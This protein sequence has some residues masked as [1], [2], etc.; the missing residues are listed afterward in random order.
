MQQYT[1][2]SIL[3]TVSNTKRE[4]LEYI[5]END[6]VTVNRIV[7]VFPIERRMVHRH[8]KSL[9]EG[10]ELIKVGVPPKV[11]YSVKKIKQDRNISYNINSETIKIINNNFTLLEPN[12]IEIEG[13]EGFVVWCT[14]KNRNYDVIEKAN[15]YIKLIKGYDNFKKNG[16]IDATQKIISTFEK[17]D[18]FLDKLYYL[19]P[20]SFPVFGKTKMGQWLFHA[21]QTQN[22]MLMQRVIY[23][24]SKEIKKLTKIKKI[25]S[26]SF[27]PPT[28]PRNLQFMSELKKYLNINL[29]I[30]KIEKIK[31]PILI[32][33]KGLKD[34]A[35]RIKNA[36]ET[37]VI[38][39]E[40]TNYKKMLLIDDFTGSG[41]TLNV[42]AGKIKKQK[43]AESV[44]GI[45]IAGSMNG[46]EVIKEL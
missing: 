18:R 35:D 39:T 33:Q 32:Q 36:E 31:T 4:I 13:F 42:L 29:P 12:G 11:Y 40:N 34:I 44:I 10:G 7:K 2:H 8:L 20:Y 38:E 14:S 17:K 23:V 41:S 30:I 19:Y 25:D 37:M 6:K 26:I 21:K 5:E 3:C 46:F 1:V 27:I 9:L 22:K 16:F 28:V 43:I 15:K 24:V 45:T